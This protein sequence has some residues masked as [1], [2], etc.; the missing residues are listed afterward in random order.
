MKFS[1][2]PELQT[3]AW[4]NT[5]QA[6]TLQSLR[7]R[8]VVLEAFQMLCPGCVSHSLPQAK[9][10]A[11][12]FP[13]DQ[14]AVIGLHTVFEHH[15]AQG[16]AAA[17]KAF[18]HEYR[19]GFP[20]GID[21]PADGGG[22]PRTMRAFN[23]QGTPTLVLLDRQGR[24]RKQM[25]GREDDLRLGAEIMALVNDAMHAGN[26]GPDEQTVNDGCDDSGCPVKPG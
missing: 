5:D 24:I 15:E 14:V 21:A 10:V 26:G 17:L 4:L 9:R 18:L 6:V 23:M 25:F 13:P 7:G 2:A 19:I 12:T 22:P 16:S 11:E 8:V 3:T 1:Q 20:V